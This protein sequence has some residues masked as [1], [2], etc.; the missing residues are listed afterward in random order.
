M[1]SEGGGKN[2][3]FDIAPGKNKKKIISMFEE[4]AAAW[5]AT[6]DDK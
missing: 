1:G 3:K 6:G 4:T 5:F 2:R